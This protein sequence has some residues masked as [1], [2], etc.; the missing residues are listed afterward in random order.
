MDIYQEILEL[1]KK[2]YSEGSTYQK[3]AE[4]KN[5]SYSY[6]RGLLNGINPPEK[7]SLEILFKLFPR[8]AI[9]LNGDKIIANGHQAIGINNGTV[10]QSMDSVIDKILS[11]DDLTAE[12]KIKVLKVLKQ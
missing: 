3:M 7:L 2:E 11:T 5:V 6:L 9:N 10:T 12:E 1:L 4:D 8:A